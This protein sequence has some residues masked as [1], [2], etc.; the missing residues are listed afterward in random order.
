MMFILAFL[1]L[2]TQSQNNHSLVGFAVPEKLEYLYTCY[3]VL[4]P[5]MEGIPLSTQVLPKPGDF[6]VKIVSQDLFII[7]TNNWKMLL[8]HVHSVMP[9]QDPKEE[10]VVMTESGDVRS[11]NFFAPDRFPFWSSAHS[12]APSGIDIWQS[13]GITIS[14]KPRYAV[15]T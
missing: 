12:L 14:V 9:K 13:G 15:S 6:T 7:S 2:N 11:N 10:Y 3:N 8:S 4:N 5:Y 1:T